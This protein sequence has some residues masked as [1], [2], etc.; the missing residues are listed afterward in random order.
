MTREDDFT[1]HLESYLEDYEGSTPLPEAT[2]DALRAAIP[3]TPQRPAWW[4]TR[5]LPLMNNVA[6]LGLA[7]AAIVVVALLGFNYLGGQNTG[8][9]GLDEPSPSPSGTPLAFPV[10]GWAPLEAGRYAIGDPFRAHLTFTLPAGWEGNIGGEYAAFLERGASRERGW[11][12][13]TDFQAVAADPCQGTFADPP[14]GPTVDDLVTALGAVT[15]IEISEVRDVTMDGFAGTELLIVAPNSFVGCQLGND[16]Y[17]IWELPLGATHT[18]SPGE[19][20]RVW[21]LDIDGKRLVITIPEPP[22]VTDEVRA[23]IQ[24][25]LD[26][27]DIEV[28]G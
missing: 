10:N 21:I 1:V 17:L 6:K 27:M 26:S 18:M 11:M 9:P 16:G 2:R 25:I 4:P 22:E 14:P 8:D 20:H 28:A 23:E 7:A 12:D 3:S 24:G 5:R 13:F 15:G 19:H